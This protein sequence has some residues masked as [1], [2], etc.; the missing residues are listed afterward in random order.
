M[1]TTVKVE[2]A[3]IHT[4]VIQRLP[5]GVRRYRDYLPLMPLVVEPTDWN[6]PFAAHSARN[7]A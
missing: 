6:Q 1:T 4:S 5:Q 7:T 2:L 3:P